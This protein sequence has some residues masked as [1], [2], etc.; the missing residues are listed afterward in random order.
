MVSS[1]RPGDDMFVPL[2]D[3]EESELRDGERVRP[4]PVGWDEVAEVAAAWCEKY[5]ADCWVER[6]L[7]LEGGD[8]RFD[9]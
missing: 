3:T 6:D 4:R 2:L 1:E 7:G 8:S 9:C 5:D